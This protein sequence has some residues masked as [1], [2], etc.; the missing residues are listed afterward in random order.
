MSK[1][2]RISGRE[3]VR[4]LEQIGFYV[5]RQRGS[6]IIMRRDQPFGRLSIPNHPEL[7]KGTLRAIIAQAG[8]EVDKFVKLL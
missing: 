4:A 7:D 2:P 5:S 8:L 3:C 6:H 1:L